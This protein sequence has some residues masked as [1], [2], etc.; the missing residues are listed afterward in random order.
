[1]YTE[2]QTKEGKKYYYRVRSVRDKNKVK[3]I[4]EYLGKDLSQN[5]R[6]DLEKK[7]DLLLEPLNL[8]IKKQEIDKLEKI[9]EKYKKTK[10]NYTNRYESF[11]AQFTFDTNAIE[12]STLDLQETS[13]ILFDHRTPKGKSLREINEVLNHKKAFDYLLN[14]NKDITKEFICKLQELIT[15]NTLRKD[16]ENQIGK[17]RSSQVYVRGANFIPPNPGETKKEMRTLLVWYTKNKNKIHPLVL[18]AYF[19]AGFESI[20]PFVDGNGRTGR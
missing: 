10:I 20:H 13:Y 5:K 18:A 17:Y 2:I 4:R 16:L 15:T 7:A 8:L 12:G 11:L 14:Y 19:H 9:K 3:K 1:M 6:K